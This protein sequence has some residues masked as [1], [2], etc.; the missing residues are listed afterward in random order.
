MIFITTEI[1]VKSTVVE[2]LHRFNSLGVDLS[3]DTDYN[4]EKE[5]FISLT[6]CVV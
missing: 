5:S 6:P 4:I 3:T 2:K 1:V